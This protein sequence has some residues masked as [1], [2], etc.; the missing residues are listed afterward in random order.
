VVAGDHL[1]PNAGGLALADGRDRF[2]AWRIDQADQSEE[3]QIGL[4]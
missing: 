3:R 4:T 1:H 2:V